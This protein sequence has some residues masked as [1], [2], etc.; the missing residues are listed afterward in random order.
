V[1]DKYA[2]TVFYTAPTVI[3]SLMAMDDSWV[4]RHSRASLRLLGSVGEPINPEAWR[5]YFEVSARL[6]VESIAQQVRWLLR[7][8]QSEQR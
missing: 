4:T 6:C 7:P 8:A 1:V 3:R 5:W 2:V